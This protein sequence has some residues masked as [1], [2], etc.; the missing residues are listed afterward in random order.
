MCVSVNALF[1]CVL[2]IVTSLAGAATILVAATSNFAP[3]MRVL[4][5]RFEADTG[6]LVRL[7]YGRPASSTPRLATVLPLTSSLLLG[8]DH[9]VSLTLERQTGTSILNIFPVQ[10]AEVLESG[11]AQVLV[12]LWAGD[13]CLLARVTRRSARLLNLR[14]GKSL[15]AQFKSVAIVNRSPSGAS[16]GVM[17]GFAPPL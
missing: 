15:Y 8:V 11:P 6:N 14:Q 7:S 1:G 9:D 4:A 13:E 5:E 2:A 12:R 10:V 16:D 3:A 17:Q